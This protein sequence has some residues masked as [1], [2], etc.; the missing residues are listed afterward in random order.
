MPISYHFRDCISLLF[1]STRVSSAIARGLYTQTF[2]T[3]IGVAP[4]LQITAYL[5]G[6]G[7]VFFED[8]RR[9]TAKYRGNYTHLYTLVHIINLVQKYLEYKR[10]VKQEAQL[11]LGDRAT[12]KHAKDS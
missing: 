5:P 9:S 6:V 11:L 1:E 4:H 7:T 8:H 12:R 10:V 3:T 2:N